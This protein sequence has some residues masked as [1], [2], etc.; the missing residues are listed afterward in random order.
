ML[1]IISVRFFIINFGGVVKTVTK[2]Y[3]IYSKK[4]YHLNENNFKFF[5]EISNYKNHS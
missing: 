4:S 5:N 2:L 1:K 3:V